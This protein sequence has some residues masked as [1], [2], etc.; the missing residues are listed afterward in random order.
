MNTGG[1]GY[2]RAAR[3][4]AERQTVKE[5]L[6]RAKAIREG[7]PGNWMSYLPEYVPFR[8]INRDLGRR[9]DKALAAGGHLLDAVLK[10]GGAMKRGIFTS[11]GLAC[12]A[13]AMGW[14]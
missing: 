12:I 6:A 7:K 10:H 2:A 5:E 9:R 11:G 1:H 14:G 8:E 3:R 4:R 13:L